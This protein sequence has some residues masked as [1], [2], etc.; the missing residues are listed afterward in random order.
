MNKREND[1]ISFCKKIDKMMKGNKELIIAID[2]PC[3][4]GKSS[5][6]KKLEKHYDANI[7]HL[8]DFFLTPELRTKERLKEPGGNVDYERFSREVIQG[9]KSKSS[10]S[11]SKYNCKSNTMIIKEVDGLRP[12]TVIEGSYS[13]HPYLRDA[14]DLKVFLTV[15]PEVQ[16]KRIFLR[17]GEDVAL[18][19][20]DLWIPLENLYFQELSIREV[21]DIVLD[22]TIEDRQIQNLI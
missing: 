13:L 14:Y 20:L 21:A 11:Y 10:F 1:F 6:A 8:D 19:F 18:R 9:I 15:E 22:G 16:M 5:L 17:N 12:L 4:S 3:G 7:F 2:G